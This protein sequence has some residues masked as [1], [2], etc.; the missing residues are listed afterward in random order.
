MTDMPDKSKLVS[1]ST[2]EADFQDALG[3]F[4][5]V[6]DQLG[7]LGTPEELDLDSSGNITPTKCN[8]IVDTENDAVATDTL[9]LIVPTNLGEKLIFIRGKTDAR[10]VTVKHMAS[11]T[12][13]I[14]LNTVQDVELKDPSYCI[15]LYWDAAATRWKE[16]WR[17][18]GLV[19]PGGT[20]AAARAQLGLGTASTRDTGIG[21]TQI[22][23]NSNL[24]T[25]AY[26]NT[27]VGS[28][29][30]PLNNQL[31]ALAFLSTVTDSQLNG[32]GVT[33]GTY[34]SVTVNAQGRVTG[35]T[36]VTSAFSQKIIRIFTTSGTYTPT[37]GMKTCEVEVQGG[38]GGAGSGGGLPG[39][40][41]GGTSS[42]GSFMTATGGG[43]GVGNGAG[44]PGTATG[45]TINRPGGW[46]ASGVSSGIATG[47]LSFLGF[48][49]M[50]HTNPNYVQPPTGWGAGGAV[51][52]IGGISGGGGVG[53]GGGYCKRIFT[54][55]Q[56]GASQTFVV[57]L[58]GGNAGG[59][60]TG[61]VYAVGGAGVII[62]TEYL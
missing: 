14:Y 46:G 39:T 13:R 2:T 11:G 5:D 55:A 47:G 50:C 1:G 49:G 17:N 6:V 19:I 20:E 37:A 51:V 40:G 48:A 38:G 33:P 34:N 58:G 60:T 16:M 18:F 23:L 31:G 61:Y 30:V 12:G 54:A 45:G 3:D 26:V 53:G 36:A 10:V 29:Q 57:G 4:Y 41:I 27:G 35:G 52:N 42:F 7:V 25:A 9:N 21:S 62:I 28:T 32:S 59:S 43:F 15:A 56:I 8:I 22:P 44:T 24:G